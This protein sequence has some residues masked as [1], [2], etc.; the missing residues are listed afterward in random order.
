MSEKIE[1]IEKPEWMS[2]DVIHDVVWRAHAHNRENG[3]VMRYPSL[4]GDEIRQHL[5]GR[6]KMFVALYGTTVVGT[7]AYLIKDSSLWCGKGKYG[8]YC[9]AALLP[10]YRKMGIYPKLCEI[11]EKELIKQGVRRILMDTHEGNKR[12][13]TI[14]KKQGFIPVDFLVRKDHFSV[15]MVKWL[16]GCPYPT[17]ICKVQFLMRKWFRKTKVMFLVLKRSCI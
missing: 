2:W 3:I 1:I 5:E 14:A 13:L 6:G 16:D 8:Y 10:T 9:F 7:A 17:I 4:Q 11:R 12:E 15:L